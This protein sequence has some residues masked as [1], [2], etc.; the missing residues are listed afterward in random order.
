VDRFSEFCFY[1]KV[2]LSYALILPLFSTLL[3]CLCCEIWDRYVLRSRTC[4]PSFQYGNESHFGSVVPDRGTLRRAAILVSIVTTH[5][6]L[7]RNALQSWGSM[8][9]IIVMVVGVMLATA[10]Y[11]LFFNL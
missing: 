4:P 7:V 3:L 11:T 9:L 10:V 1:E 8:Q 2:N 6:T 5:N